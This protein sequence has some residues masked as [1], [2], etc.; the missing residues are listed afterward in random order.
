[1]RYEGLRLKEKILLTRKL[2][3]F[4]LA[5][6]K[7]KYEI[8]IHYG[9]IPMPKKTLIKE[10]ADAKGLIC[11][12][13]DTVDKDVIDAAT[14][15]VAISTYSVGYDHIDVKHAASKGIKI[16]YTPKVLSDTTSDLTFALIL[17]VTRRISEG[18]RTIRNGLWREIYGAYDFLG[19]D[20]RSKTLG[21]LGLGRIGKKVAKRAK[22]FGMKVIYTN[23]NKLPASSEKKY[24][25]TDTSFHELLKKSDILSLHVPYN[26]QTHEIINSSTLKKMKK[27]AF[28]INT[29]RGKIINERDLILALKQKSIGGAALD[30][31]STE[32]VKT[33]NP[34]LKLNNV[35]LSPHIGS[36]TKETRNKMAELTLKNLVLAMDGKD[37]IYSVS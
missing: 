22:A 9:E 18:D 12:P 28:L 20:L 34:L 35:V 21:I 16:G 24:S 26:Q 1:M 14:N 30:V 11:F 23:R 15:L 37:P 25:A 36:S 33:T 31:F 13:Y 6:L 29:S 27:N 3:D 19:T 4:V 10:I 32:P 8:Q 5:E 17:D 7:K 2:H